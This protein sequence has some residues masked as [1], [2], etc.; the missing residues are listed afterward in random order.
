[1]GTTSSS[2]PYTPTP[3]AKDLYSKHVVQAWADQQAS[4]DSFDNNLLTVS[5]AALGLSIAFIKDIVPLENAEWLA[6][7]YVSWV[8]F[9]TCIM[10][11]IASFQ[12]AAMA[13][14]EHSKYLADYYLKGDT[15]VLN[16]INPWA[17]LL[18]WCALAGSVLMLAGILAT[19]TFAAHNVTHFKEIKIWQT[20]L[21]LKK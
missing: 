1:V 15:S 11:T 6:S 7:L 20:K 21:P 9:G 14:K 12:I 17:K 3:E 4:S 16:K 18:P 8:S 13:Q 2:P 19:L 5:S 10:V